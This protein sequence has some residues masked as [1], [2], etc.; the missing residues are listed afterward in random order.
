MKSIELAA[1]VRLRAPAKVNLGLE[2]VARRPDGYH[3]VVTI[4]QSVS[5][6]DTIDLLP[7]P[8]LRYTPPAGLERESDLLWRAVRLAEDRFGVRLRAEIRLEKHIPL[9]A[10]LG[11]GS[12]DAGTLLGALAVLAGIPLNEVERAAA[13]LGS[14]VPFFV[15]GGTALAT[16]TGTDL[17]PLS[18]PPNVWFVVV[19]PDLVIP[20]KTAAL[21][22]ALTPDH[23]TDGVAT[24]RLAAALERGDTLDP[25]LMHNTFT[26]VLREWDAVS[27]AIDA[28]HA[29]GAQVV[30]PSGAGPSVF[31][32]VP[33]QAVANAIADRLPTGIG[34][35]YVCTTVARDSNASALQA[36][37]G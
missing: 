27:R 19:A 4:L 3:E 33:A 20:A 18:T 16:G 35:V 12:S 14:D 15:R 8:A 21:Y 23:F 6:F 22:G 2:V 24:R 13:A 5:L 32:V 37:V 10:G 7:A 26:P 36:A 29:A 11:G 34:R 30:L 31:T 28:L 1:P 9:A 17:A 25:D